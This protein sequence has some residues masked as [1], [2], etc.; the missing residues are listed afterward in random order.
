MKKKMGAVGGILHG[1]AGR[2]RGREHAANGGKRLDGVGGGKVCSQV[3]LR[4]S[5]PASSLVSAGL[6]CVSGTRRF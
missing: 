4:V 1:W 2:A 5:E 6:D 3:W